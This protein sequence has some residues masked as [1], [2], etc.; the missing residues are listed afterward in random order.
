MSTNEDVT[1]YSSLRVS[2]GSHRA[3]MQAPDLTCQE[4]FYD[5]DITTHGES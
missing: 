3:T 4:R 2:D 5:P 1:Y